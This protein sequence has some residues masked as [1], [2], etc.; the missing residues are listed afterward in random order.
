MEKLNNRLAGKRA[1]ISGGNQGI[2]RAISIA[3]IE[4]GCDIFVHYFSSAK[5]KK[6]LIELSQSRNQRIGFF[7]GDL[8]IEAD[9]VN[10]INNAIKKLEGMNLRSYVIFHHG[11]N[12][13]CCGNKCLLSLCFEFFTFMGRWVGPHI[14]GLADICGCGGCGSGKDTLCVRL[15]SDEL[16]G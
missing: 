3:L 12:D 1:L 13:N 6:E 11:C 16:T 2:G 9:A 7:Q 15:F 8:T 14:D 5:Y 10:C 4:S